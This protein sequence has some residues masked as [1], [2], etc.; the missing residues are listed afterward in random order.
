MGAYLHPAA[1][2]AEAGRIFELFPRL[3][4][5]RRERAGNLSGGERRMLS[6]GLTLLLQP[7]LL[8]LD[9]PS[10]DLAPAMVDLVFDVIRSIR[11]ALG[12]PILLVEQNVQ[13]ALSLAERVAV[14]VRGRVALD[15]PVG[16][17]ELSRLHSLFL[18]GGVRTGGA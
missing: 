13:K 12:I 15:A 3:K 8:L 9:E 17:I 6:I 11:L 1:F 14:L 2:A 5:R 16:E 4:E 18:D 7:K 10:S